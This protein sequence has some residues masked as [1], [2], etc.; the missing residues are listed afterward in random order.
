MVGRDISIADR[1]DE[2]PFIVCPG[3]KNL[4]DRSKLEAFLLYEPDQVSSAQLAF[5]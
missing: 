2:N 4:R 1:L 3:I 5:I